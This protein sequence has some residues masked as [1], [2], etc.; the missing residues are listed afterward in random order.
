MKVTKHLRICGVDGGLTG[1]TFNRGGVIDLRDMLTR[2]L[3]ETDA[4]RKRMRE[5]NASQKP[6]RSAS[7]KRSA[8][9]GGDE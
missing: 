4:A 6:K 7:K 3:R 2:L 1:L 8:R 9:S 5:K